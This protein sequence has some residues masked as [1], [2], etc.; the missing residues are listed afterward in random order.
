MWKGVVGVAELVLV[1]MICMGLDGHHW[2]VKVVLAFH[3]RLFFFFLLI[4]LCFNQ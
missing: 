1:I 3:I 2:G 4:S